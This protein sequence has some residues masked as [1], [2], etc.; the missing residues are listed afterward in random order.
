LIQARNRGVYVRAIFNGHLAWQGD[1]RQPRS[2]DDEF[3]RPLL[4][5]LQRLKDNG[6][7]LILVYGIHEHPIPY[8]PIHSKQCVIDGHTVI[9]GSFN[10]YNTSVH[11]HDLILV[12]RDH[13]VARHYLHEAQQILDTFRVFTLH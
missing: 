4:P 6:I 9:D 10:W 2:M 1:I 13:D 11:S 7:P 12:V 8:S 3:R 5:A